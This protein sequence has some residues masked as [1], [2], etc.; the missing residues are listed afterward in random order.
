VEND[1]EREFVFGCLDHR[2]RFLE[3]MDDDFN[4]GAAIGVLFELA[5]AINRFVDEHRLEARDDARLAALAGGAV[6]TLRSVAKL[7]GLFERPPA[8]GGDGD[9]FVDELMHVLV[10]LRAQARTSK[11]FELADMVRDRLSQL[12]VQLEDRPEGTIW[13]RGR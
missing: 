2:A 6:Q 11:Q 3:V 4:T 7:L 1:L 12:G 5:S 13:R 8:A 10:D 9:K